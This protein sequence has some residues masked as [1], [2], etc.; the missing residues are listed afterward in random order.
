MSLA[1]KKAAEQDEDIPVRSKEIY[2][3]YYSLY[4]CYKHLIGI[5]SH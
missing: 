5:G 2:I 4:Y 3:K 1:L